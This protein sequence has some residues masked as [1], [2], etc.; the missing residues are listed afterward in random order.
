MGWDLREWLDKVDKMGE[1]R[2]IK[3]AH[4]D[5]EMGALTHLVHENLGHRAPAL[6][7]DEVP[8]Y[9]EGYRTLY[10]QL[11]SLKRIALTLG[12]PMKYRSKG[13]IVK[14][15]INKMNNLAP[16]RPVE[17]SKGR[18]QENIQKGK[19]INVLSF[20]VPR[21]HELDR[22]RYIATAS[23][24]I[25]KDPDEGWYN[26]GTYR[27]QVFDGKTIGLQI[28]EGKHGRIHL[29]KYFERGE[30]MKVAILV[31]QDPLLYLLS[32]SRI[33]HGV[34]EYDI[35][36]AIRGE[37]VE[38][39]RGEYTDFPIPASAE[40]VIEG[41]VVPGR[42][43]EEGPFGEWMGYYCSKPKS[44][45]Y[46]NVKCVMHRNNPIL[47]CA[48]QHKPIDETALMKSVFVSAE[49]WRDLKAVGIPEIIGVWNH[50]GAMGIRFLVVSIKQRYPGHARQ[51]LHVASSSQAAAYNGKFVVV[52]DDDID[53]SDINQVMW[54]L[55]T[56]FDPVEDIDIIKKAW[57]SGRDPLATDGSNFNNRIL[58]DACIPY[59]RLKSGDFPQ[60]VDVSKDMREK[61]WAKWGNIL[62]G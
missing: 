35:A 29:D 59:N 55:T 30:A 37:P 51:V 48:P 38:V 26:L 22:A 17:V 39:I 27:C 57:S 44:R 20:P 45:H 36:G 11:S 56:R 41:E 21:H 5:V 43:K 23:C 9:P 33:P 3:G 32:S 61:I 10:G 58:V 19:K 52:V 40:I 13:E 28:T 12:L 6:L 31:G 54:A 49:V 47:C 62:R 15:Y 2:H 46:V 42:L 53:P 14:A 16:V 7:F 4:W 1:L 50:E 8:G 60:V 24:V 25:T 34:C 18:V